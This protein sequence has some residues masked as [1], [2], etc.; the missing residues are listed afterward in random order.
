MSLGPF[1]ITLLTQHPPLGR[2]GLMVKVTVSSYRGQNDADLTE[3][4]EIDA[5][6]MGLVPGDGC[7][8]TLQ[9][10]KNGITVALFNSW[11][12]AQVME[13]SS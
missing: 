12:H 6:S 7:G 11:S 5:D 9:V 3:T 13:A 10:L 1:F 4:Y 2:I 8:A